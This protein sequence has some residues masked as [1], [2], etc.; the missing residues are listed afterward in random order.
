MVETLRKVE[1][2]R[3]A[4][5]DGS[6]RANP[7]KMENA[8]KA[9]RAALGGPLWVQGYVDAAEAYARQLFA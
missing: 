1:S 5:E 3:G 4:F 6:L 9:K 2:A 7:K 8:S